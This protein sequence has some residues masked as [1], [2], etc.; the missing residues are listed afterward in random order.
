M[1]WYVRSDKLMD[2]D[3][4]FYTH[5]SLQL[6]LYNGSM[7]YISISFLILFCHSADSIESKN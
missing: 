4:E 5:K 3:L 1:G 6:E 7:P 2:T